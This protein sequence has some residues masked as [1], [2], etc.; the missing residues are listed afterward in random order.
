M[1]FGKSASSA[2]NVFSSKSG[3]KFF[4]KRSLLSAMLPV[5]LA[6]MTPAFAQT[7]SVPVKPAVATPT[8]SSPATTWPS[9][10]Y[11]PDWR[12][13][14]TNLS[15]FG[16]PGTNTICVA[17]DG[18]VRRP[19]RYYLSRSSSMKD[20]I[21]EAQDFTRLAYLAGHHCYLLRADSNG[22]PA[23]EYITRE[24]LKEKLALPLRNWDVLFIGN[25]VYWTAIV[26]RDNIGIGRWQFSPSLGRPTAWLTAEGRT[27]AESEA[28]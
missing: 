14:P 7:A 21:S 3:A 13:N 26:S 9:S 11:L 6:T 4:R 25:E 8:N 28:R 19:G 20:A 15:T 18:Q 27:L 5:C 23:L 22:V 16:T 10:A 1:A 17:V 2:T 24:N 12:T